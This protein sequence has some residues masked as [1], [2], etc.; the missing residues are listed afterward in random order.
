MTTLLS[1]ESI[2]H[3]VREELAALLLGMSVQ[4]LREALTYEPDRDLTYEQAAEM[5][6][7][8][9]GAL[10]KRVHRG[11]IPHKRYGARTVRFSERAL[12]VEAV[13]CQRRAS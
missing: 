13:R 7:M 10:Q 3:D 2:E 8:T 6:G 1:R 4:R 9:V 12:R 11:T 5:L